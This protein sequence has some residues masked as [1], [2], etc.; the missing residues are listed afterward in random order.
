[1]LKRG[2][3]NRSA[4][5]RLGVSITEVLV[6]IG[7]IAILLAI[8]I[9]AVQYSREAARR[10]QCQNNQRQILLAC[11][12][13]EATN[14]SLPSLYNGTSLA[15]PLKEWDLFHM[16]SWRVELLP[17][18]EQQPLR[19]KI[20][21]SAMATDPVNKSVLEAVVP[22]YVCPSGA[23]PLSN[24]GW[25]A[26]HAEWPNISVPFT[27]IKYFATRSDYDA[28]VGIQLL[29]AAG[30]DPLSTKFVRWG[31]W[32]WPDFGNGKFAGTKL[33]RYRAGKF[34]DVTDGLS[35]TI[36]LVERGGKPIDLLRGEPHVTPDNPEAE[37]PGQ[38]GWSASNTFA[39]AINENAVAVNVSNS[40]GIYSL[41]SGG[42]TVAMA[43]GS[44]R[45]LSEST[46]Y[47]ELVKLFSRSGGPDE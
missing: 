35:N 40:K 27:G 19:D 47:E 6:V 17:Y 33:L 3:G 18:L 32:G 46:S 30:S 1:M 36:A 44:V 15:Y 9:P 14:G 7:I 11:Q 13:F 37:Y 28:M 42:A 2:L 38:V 10:T 12:A 5:K 20:D 31:I 24:M 26:A 34:R 43:D 29:P 25:G 23:D 45:F 4:S 8:T 22:V 16:H 21:W 39:W 41:H